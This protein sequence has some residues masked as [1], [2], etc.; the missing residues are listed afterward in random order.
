[1][2]KMITLQLTEKQAQELLR[3]LCGRIDL[4]LTPKMKEAGQ[5]GNM[6]TMVNLTEL[7]TANK[8]ILTQLE[9]LGVSMPYTGF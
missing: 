4:D 2:E 6:E 7:Y 8:S 5:K 9:M 3:T 1:M